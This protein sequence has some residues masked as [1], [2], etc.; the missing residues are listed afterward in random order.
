[1]ISTDAYNLNTENLWNKTQ[2]LKQSEDNRVITLSKPLTDDGFILGNLETSGF[3]RV[4]YDSKSWANI[5][6]QLNSNK[7]V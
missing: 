2:W 3:Y 5:I 4:N 6:Q 1:V 7:N